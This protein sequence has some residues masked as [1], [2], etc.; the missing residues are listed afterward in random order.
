MRTN[1]FYIIVPRPLPLDVRL[2]TP[3][4]RVMGSYT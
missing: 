1:D 4:T 2:T 3:A